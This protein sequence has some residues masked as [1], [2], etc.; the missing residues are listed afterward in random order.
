MCALLSGL[1][2]NRARCAGQSF[3]N[4][5]L[6]DDRSR[7][8]DRAD[9]RS[10]D[11][12]DRPAEIQ[13]HDARPSR[14]ARGPPSNQA[15]ATAARGPCRSSRRLRR[16]E[17]SYAGLAVASARP[18][19]ARYRIAATTRALDDASADRAR[20][21]RA[22]GPA[23]RS[24]ASARAALFDGA[25]GALWLAQPSADGLGGNVQFGGKLLASAVVRQ[26]GPPR[27]HGR[28]SWL[29]CPSW[30]SPKISGCVRISSINP[31]NDWTGAT[32]RKGLP[33]FANSPAIST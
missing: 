18:R 26:L 13:S 25:V 9:A 23:P 6:P 20:H 21:R 4:V 16:S 28:S 32:T 12:R 3:S 33:N 27:Q 29:P 22:A 11:S 2:L 1:S 14:S 5:R 8:S 7:V 17:G 24:S 19:A 10:G 30:R 31:T 15:C